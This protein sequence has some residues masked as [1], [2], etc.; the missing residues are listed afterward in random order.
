MTLS[1]IRDGFR[2]FYEAIGDTPVSITLTREAYARVRL[3]EIEGVKILCENEA[4]T[5]EELLWACMPHTVTL[6]FLSNRDVL[7]NLEPKLCQSEGRIGYWAPEYWAEH[8]K[9]HMP[10]NVLVRNFGQGAPGHSFDLVVVRELHEIK[11]NE[12]ALG[13]LQSNVLARLAPNGKVVLLGSR[14]SKDDVY[15]QLKDWTTAYSPS[16][17]NQGRPL[18]GKSLDYYWSVRERVGEAMWRAEWQQDPV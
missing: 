6:L 14:Q 11:D 3:P 7:N 5:A 12:M 2:L 9:R 15:S 17:D 8:M 13:F 18:H 1:K 4:F 10:T 16:V